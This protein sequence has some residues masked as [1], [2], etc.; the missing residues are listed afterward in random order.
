MQMLECQES[1]HTLLCQEINFFS[2]LSII[3]LKIPQFKD[4]STNLK[5]TQIKLAFIYITSPITFTALLSFY[6]NHFGLKH[7][8]PEMTGVGGSLKADGDTS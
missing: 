2:F 1:N 3:Q 5:Y 7:A 4:L 6:D 8:I